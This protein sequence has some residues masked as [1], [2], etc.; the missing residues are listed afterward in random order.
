MDSTVGRLAFSRKSGEAFY[1]GDLAITLVR[2][3]QDMTCDVITEFPDS[4]KKLETVENKGVITPL[5]DVSIELDVNTHRGDRI[6]V[7]VTAPKAIKI[8]RAELVHGQQKP[9]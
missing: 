5:P 1:V 2:R 4:T 7:L 6:Q 9:I 3:T 8:L